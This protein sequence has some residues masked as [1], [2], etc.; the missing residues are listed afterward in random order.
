[1][2]V[3]C[4]AVHLALPTVGPGA[5]TG[6][7]ESHLDTCVRCTAEVAGYRKMYS[8]LEALETS[9]EPAPDDL[10]T[11]VMKRLGLVAVAD[12]QPHR[13]HRIPVA[14]AAVVATAAAGTV[15]L[16]KLYRERA[17]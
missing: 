8:Q 13:D 3:V 17:A 14:A 11:N 2:N 15:V 1:M 7:L 6:A 4:T 5:V 16:V 12:W 9:L 10:E